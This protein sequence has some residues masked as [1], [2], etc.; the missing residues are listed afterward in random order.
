MTDRNV[1]EM[2]KVGGRDKNRN[3]RLPN[4]ATREMKKWILA[5]Y[6]NPFPVYNQKKTWTS[7]FN[8]TMEQVNTFMANNRAR[9]LGRLRDRIPEYIQIIPGPTKCV[10]M[11]MPFL[12]G[13]IAPRFKA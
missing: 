1:S 9:L 11:W 7:Q 4:E 8:L 6:A 2:Q 5:N 12:S 3:E 10:P 13:L